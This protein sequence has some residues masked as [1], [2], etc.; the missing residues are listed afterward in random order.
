[1]PRISS[2]NAGAGN[3]ASTSRR[4]CRGLVSIRFVD[5]SFVAEDPSHEPEKEHLVT[6]LPNAK[7]RLIGNHIVSV[8]SLSEAIAHPRE[9]RATILAGAYAHVLKHNH[10]SGDP[11][12]SDAD[13]RLMRKIHEAGQI[14]EISLLDHVIAGVPQAG[15]APYFSFREVG[16]L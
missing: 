13:R 15:C 4:P 9:Y 16:L 6:A 8:D 1:V 14:M 10:P 7:L 2:G 11:A 3:P 12:P 5:S